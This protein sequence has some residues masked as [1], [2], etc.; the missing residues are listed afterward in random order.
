MGNEECPPC[1]QRTS[2]HFLQ[3]RGSMHLFGSLSMKTGDTPLRILYTRLSGNVPNTPKPCRS[4]RLAPSDEDC[5]HRASCT[6][7]IVQNENLLHRLQ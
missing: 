3:T 5:P 1:K 7:D 6:F 2:R 4:L